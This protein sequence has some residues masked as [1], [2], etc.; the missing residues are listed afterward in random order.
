MVISKQ[1]Y[2]L[3]CNILCKVE[4]IKQVGTFEYLGF[5]ITPDARCDTE[6]KKKRGLSKDTFTKMKS[7]FTNRK[8]RIYTKINT[9]K[10]YAWSIL[11][12]GCECWTLSKELERRIGAAEMWYIRRIMRISWTEKRS[13]EEE[14][15][16]AG[17]KISLLKT[18]RTKQLQFWGHIKRAGGLEKQILS[19]KICGTKSRGRHA[20]NTQT[21]WIT[22]ELTTERIERLWSPMSVTDLAHDEDDFNL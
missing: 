2:I 22:R 6:I 20:Q 9:L 3:V 12:Q 5:T 21:V 18:I 10:A 17:S 8:I 13:N 11:L 15:E 7:I 14:L 4:R 1:S 16:M 19:G